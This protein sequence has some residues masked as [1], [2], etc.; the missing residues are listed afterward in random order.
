MLEGREL[1]LQLLKRL[2]VGETGG[3]KT[4]TCGKLAKLI[5]ERGGGDCL[6]VAADLQR[7]AAVEQLYVLGKQ[8]GVPVYS[9]PRALDPNVDRGSLDPVQVCQDGVRKAREQNI[10][11]VILDTAGR[12]AIDQELMQQLGH[13]E[14][15]VQPDQV[16][17]V[18]DGMT[19]QDAVNSASAFVPPA[20][21]VNHAR[22]N[23]TS[24]SAAW[25]G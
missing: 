12:L 25:P 15:R 13:I 19:G 11:V 5:K 4:T 14:K 23:S 10:R 18:V 2:A 20:C 1:L 3:G 21:S 22:W 24:G 8:L 9:D 6:L 16:Y 7:P 17:L